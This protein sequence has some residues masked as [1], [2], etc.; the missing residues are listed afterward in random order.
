MLTI[1]GIFEEQLHLS[2]LVFLI[3]RMGIVIATG[4][5]DSS[6]QCVS[7]DR[8]WS[9]GPIL[10]LAGPSLC[11]KIFKYVANIQKVWC[12]HEKN[13]MIGA[14][15]A[16]SRPSANMSTCPFG[17]HL[18]HPS[19]LDPSLQELV[20]GELPPRLHSLGLTNPSPGRS[21]RAPPAPAQH[22]PLLLPRSAPQ[23]PGAFCLN[24]ASPCSLPS[25]CRGSP[26]LAVS[27]RS[28][29]GADR[30]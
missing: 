20:Q 26:S 18:S 4:L 28:P 15:W 5:C 27:H 17:P 16:H 13:E 24:R 23:C 29:G 14:C 12:C 22:G 7:D 9:P 21:A 30:T 25:L 6:V 19:L 8:T 3:C 10:G 2:S 1:Y 11:F